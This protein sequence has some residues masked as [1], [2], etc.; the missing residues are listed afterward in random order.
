MT[1]GVNCEEQCG[2]VMVLTLIVQQEQILW[3]RIYDKGKC[4]D[5]G[6]K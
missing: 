3:N 1:C 4:C 5:W 2:E 6:V